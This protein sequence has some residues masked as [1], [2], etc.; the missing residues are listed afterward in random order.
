VTSIGNS[1]FYGCKGLTSIAI[2][3]SV[4]SIGEN[5]FFNCSGLTSVTI[6]SGVAS[7]G[8]WAFNGCS[9][10]TSIKCRV[11]SQPSG[12]DSV[13]KGNCIV[14]PVWGYTGA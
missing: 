9:S 1:A 3:N 14:T 6:G 2:P 11:A 8:A 7:I 13:W 10:L 5:A 4:T 12:W